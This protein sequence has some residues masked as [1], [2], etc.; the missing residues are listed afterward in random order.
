[1]NRTNRRKR[2]NN[3]TVNKKKNKGGSSNMDLNFFPSEK[4]STQPN[5]DSSYKEI[6]VLHITESKGINAVR[7]LA[8]GIS[9]LFGAKGFDNSVVDTLRNETLAN[10]E[11]NIKKNQKVCNLRMEIDNPDPGLLFHHV[12]G[13][14]LEKKGIQKTP[15]INNPMLQNE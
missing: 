7:G 9:N 11:K 10:L 4:I 1:M 2:R 8:T 15:M 5:F 14:L 3:K 6:G 12:Y 13:T